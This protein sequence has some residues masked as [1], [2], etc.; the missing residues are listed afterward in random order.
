[1]SYI[2]IL[3]NVKVKNEVFF[4][5]KYFLQNDFL[6]NLDTFKYMYMLYILILV[7]SFAFSLK[8]ASQRAKVCPKWS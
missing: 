8:R 7:G 1:M 5:G 2:F 4:V 3:S 6:Q